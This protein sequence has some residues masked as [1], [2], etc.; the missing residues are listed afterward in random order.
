MY[1]A[2]KDILEY[3]GCEQSQ[4]NAT[5][6]CSWLVHDI[7]MEGELCR[8]GT[9]LHFDVSCY[10]LHSNEDIVHCGVGYN[11]ISRSLSLLFKPD[12]CLAGLAVNCSFFIFFNYFKLMKLTV[13]SFKLSEESRSQFLFLEA[14]LSPSPRTSALSSS[15]PPILRRHIYL[16][17]TTYDLLRHITNH[18]T[19]TRERKKNKLL[20]YTTRVPFI[21]K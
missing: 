10:W 14:L 6:T 13:S 4:S 7:I 1:R 17:P 11:S 20:D 16:R 12:A 15:S 3:T 18:K 9:P 8:S 2:K 19:H 5:T 21:K